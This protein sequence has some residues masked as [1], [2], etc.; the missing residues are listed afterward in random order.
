MLYVCLKLCTIWPFQK[1]Y[2]E[3]RAEFFGTHIRAIYPD[4]YSK[5][6][7]QFEK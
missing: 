3:Q 2:V 4:D 1:F 7:A 5:F 6:F